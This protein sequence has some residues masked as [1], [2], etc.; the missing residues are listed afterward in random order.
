[1]WRAIVT[2]AL[3]VVPFD[4][5]VRG[6]RPEG[7]SKATF[8]AL[9]SFKSLIVV[10]WGSLT[11]PLIPVPKIASMTISA[12]PNS[13]PSFVTS[14]PS[15]AT[16]TSAA[17]SPS[18]LQL[19]WASVVLM[20][21]GLERRRTFNFD[22]LAA[23]YLAATKPSPPLLPLPATTRTRFPKSGPYLLSTSRATSAPA[24]S[25]NF[26]T[27]IPR[28]AARASSFIICSGVMYSTCSAKRNYVY[29][30]LPTSD[31][32]DAEAAAGGKEGLRV[33]H[34]H[35][36]SNDAHRRQHRRKR[37]RW[38]NH[39]VHGRDS[40]D[41]GIPPRSNERGDRL[42][43]PDELLRSRLHRRPLD[44][45]SRGKLRGNDLDGGGC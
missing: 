24:F 27:P 2:S 7:M 3:T 32:P 44:T 4:S 29:E 43:R 34:D 21:S 1:M 14:L 19:V 10:E 17:V 12:R 42:H 11:S 45:E 25:I 40:R 28:L 13:L 23:R 15:R 9:D 8:F 20:A 30:R 31:S 37:L 38:L 36:S 22:P 6:S 33:R 26:P 16:T 35:L 41:S 39:E 18:L 5:P